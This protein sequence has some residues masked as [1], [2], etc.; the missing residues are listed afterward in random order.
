[1]KAGLKSIL[2]I[3]RL[4]NWF[5]IASLLF[6]FF[7][8]KLWKYEK[9]VIFWDVLEYYS[10][11]PATFIHHDLTLSFVNGNEKLYANKFW[12]NKAP[13]GSN[14][15]K[16]T[17]G[18]SILYSPFFFIAHLIA[19]ILGFS[20]DG[21]TEPYRV[22]LLL[23]SIIYLAIGLFFLRTIL[24]KYFTKYTTAITLLVIGC[25]TNLFYYTSIEPCMTHAY[26]FTLFTIFIYLTIKWYE[27]NSISHLIFIG[28]LGGLI[29]LIRPT[30][31]FIFLFFLLW[32]ITSFQDLKVRLTFFLKNFK[33]LFLILF[34]WFLVLFPQLLYWKI[35]SGQWIYYSYRDEH[36][37][38]GNP[39]IINGLFSYRK[40]WLLY[41]PVM[42]FALA[43]IP[44]LFKKYKEF[45]WPVLI[46]TILNIY[47]IFSWWTW[48]Y[49]G[50][51]GQRPMI[52]S[53]GLLAIPLAVFIEWILIRR[54]YMKI[55]YVTLLAGFIYL[56]IFQTR[57]AYHGAIHFDSMTKKAYWHSFGKL[58]PDAE[59]Y[60]L[61]SKPNYELAKKG[62]YN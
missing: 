28:L 22:A 55:V 8:Y 31:I 16:M 10:Y 38:F 5:I 62:I 41:T 4:A 52:D 57:Q 61:L 18:L 26:N 23:S 56:N 47:V 53:Y 13:N 46:F 58:H 25:G 2:S 48:W 39:Q 50:S 19:K 1:M 29:T 34:F 11:L 30:N 60:Q 14:V 49:G 59:F 9:K 17:M 20:T 36:F 32:K 7:S 44:L 24:L 51:F 3:P 21:Y 35:V 43:G 6:A 27:K 12:P 42:I 45:F 54:N 37:F 15:L 40:G 33:Y